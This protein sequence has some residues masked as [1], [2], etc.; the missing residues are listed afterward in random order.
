MKYKWLNRNGNREIIIFFN[1][2]GMDEN[3]VSHLMF[4]KYDVITFFDYNDLDTDFE[5]EELEKYS[6]KYLIS[7]SMG[8]MVASLFNL[9]VDKSIAINGTLTPIDD[10]YGIPEKIYNLTEKGLTEE[11]IKKF[12]NKM[13]LTPDMRFSCNRTFESR[14]K[15]LSA[16]KKYQPN[17]DFKYDDVYISLCDKIIP[18][19]NQVAFWNKEPNLNSGHCPFFEFSSW[20]ELV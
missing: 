20:E 13:F 6:K 19:Q 10:N 14:K 8:V 3:V 11:S 18:T 7:W 15:E 16:L 17:K 2:W 1:G 9:S 5:F 12:V 4:D